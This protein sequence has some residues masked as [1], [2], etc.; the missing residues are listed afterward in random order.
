MY[1]RKRAS[2]SAAERSLANKAAGRIGRLAAL[3]HL[4]WRVAEREE[5]PISLGD[6]QVGV[7][8]MQ[9]AIRFNQF[10]LDQIGRRCTPTLERMACVRRLY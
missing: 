2:I 10:L 8:A 6:N 4:L 7:E 5:G 1:Q 9:R 3:F